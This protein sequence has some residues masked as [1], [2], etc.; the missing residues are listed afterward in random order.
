MVEQTSNKVLVVVPGEEKCM[1]AV[2]LLGLKD[3]KKVIAKYTYNNHPMIL[4]KELQRVWIEVQRKKTK[5]E[6]FI[7]L[8][9][10]YGFVVV[11]EGEVT[12][13]L[14]CYHDSFPFIQ[15]MKEL[16]RTNKGKES[17]VD[18]RE[19]DEILTRC[20]TIIDDIIFIVREA[21]EDIDA[22]AEK[23]YDI[24]DTFQNTFVI[25]IMKNMRK[26]TQY[27][28]RV[29]FIHQENCSV[30]PNKAIDGFYGKR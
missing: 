10:R 21:G 19:E 23:M 26:L 7:A 17:E 24:E 28:E 20:S 14:R 12:Q 29:W 8:H 22:F 30:D 25:S 1:N 5:I 11:E 13:Y 3:G 6:W 4:L 9:V 2:T 15:L 27:F 16:R 18:L